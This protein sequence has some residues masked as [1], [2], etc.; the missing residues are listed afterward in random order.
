[1]S[2]SPNGQIVRSSED[3]AITDAHGNVWRLTPVVRGVSV[4]GL[5]IGSP[6]DVVE[7]VYAGRRV[8][9]RK[10]HD[11]WWS[12]QHATEQ[13]VKE[14]HAPDLS[15]GNQAEVVQALIHTK[16]A[17]LQAIN[18]LAESAMTSQHALAAILHFVS[19]GAPDLTATTVRFAVPSRRN[20]TTGEPI[21]MA[22]NIQDDVVTVIPLVFDNSAGSAVPAPSGGTATVTVDNTANFS[23][24]L[25]ADG[26]SVL[27]TPNQPPT[28]GATGTITYTDV[29]D[30]KTLTATLDGLVITADANA[31]SVHFDT[32]H[33]TTE[34]LPAPAPAPTPAP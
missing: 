21:P 29:V 30:G 11:S 14:P 3:P 9:V 31:V 20:L 18:T 33:L 5:I 13:W 7:M 19:A 34:P 12:K 17:I 32:A 15:G 6:R 8:W 26:M 10:E 1:M 23:V 22:I 24:A 28:D 25:S 2:E 16:H 4:N 27:V